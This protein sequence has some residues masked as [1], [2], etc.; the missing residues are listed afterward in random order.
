MQEALRLRARAELC[1]RFLERASR[2]DVR[3]ALAALIRAYE[4]AAAAR[5][6]TPAR[7]W[8]E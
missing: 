2:Q 1:R 7:T 6:V 5:V 4:E 3:E 8:R